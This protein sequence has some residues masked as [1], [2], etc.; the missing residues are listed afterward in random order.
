MKLTTSQKLEIK[1]RIAS[2]TGWVCM[3]CGCAVS[4]AVKPSCDK[5]AT[6]EH[7]RRRCDGGKN[8]MDNFGLACRRCNN[9]RHGKE[10]KVYDVG[11]TGTVIYIPHKEVKV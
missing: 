4:I 6:I 2:E 11:V 8:K 3:W 1:K 7:I 9:E 5:F 10:D